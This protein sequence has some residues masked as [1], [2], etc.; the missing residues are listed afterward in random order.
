[1]KTAIPKGSAIYLRYLD[2]T[3]FR[4]TSKPINQPAE[5]ETLGW[6]T[7]EHDEVICI[8]WDKPVHPLPNHTTSPHSGL[9]ILKSCIQ[10]TRILPSPKAQSDPLISTEPHDINAEYALQTRREKLCQSSR[11]KPERKQ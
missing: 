3:L 6:L 7:N 11:R 8:I 5:R 2:H 1:M 4:N 10:E 9:V